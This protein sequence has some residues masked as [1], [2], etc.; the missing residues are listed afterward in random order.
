MAEVIT[1]QGLRKK[2]RNLARL[3]YKHFLLYRG[4]VQNKILNDFDDLTKSQTYF[5]IIN[6]LKH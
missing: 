6:I 3:S 5:I 1:G 2:S 4:R